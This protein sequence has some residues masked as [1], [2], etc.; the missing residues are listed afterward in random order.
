ME[1]DI[2]VV[3]LGTSAGVPTIERNVPSILIRRKGEYIFFDFGEGTQRQI[4]KLGLG[5][6]RKMKIFISHMH[7]D[8]IFG[9]L[10]LLQTL[11]LFKRREPLEVYGPIKLRS[12]LKNN[13]DLLEIDLPFELVFNPI[14]NNMEY[15]F[16]EYI[17]KAIKNRHGG[18]SF[19]F[20]LEE[21]SRLGK[22][23]VEK[24]SSE[25]I[26]KEYWSKLA[27]GKDV[28]VNGK[29]YKAED[30]IIP[31][32]IKGRVIVYTGDTMAFDELITFS[33]DADVLISEA[34]FT[35][36]LKARSIETM[37]MTASEAAEIAKKANVKIL[38]LTHFSARY[39][40]LSLHLR[41]ARKIFPATFVAKDL[42]RLIIPYVTP[43][44]KLR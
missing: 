27:G 30:Y 41:E 3:F 42:D 13:I 43:H 1:L 44:S 14:Y 15:D 39:N 28:L 37:H 29:L 12:F 34:T 9:L 32:P 22:F 11:S 25:G 6:G 10:P 18:S 36:D 33:R 20:R 17:V 19:S 7:G 26:P 8:H 2:E 23:N 21:K 38:V 5:F 4:F 40:D 31:P 24:A 16:G 35:D